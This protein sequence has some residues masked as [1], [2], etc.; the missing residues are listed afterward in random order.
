MLTDVKELAVLRRG[1]SRRTSLPRFD[2]PG[3]LRY[4]QD[5]SNRKMF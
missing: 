4:W 1:R 3:A 5:Q 2:V